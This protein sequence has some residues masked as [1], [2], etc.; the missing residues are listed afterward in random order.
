[1]RT[2][3]SSYSQPRL[4]GGICGGI[5]QPRASEMRVIA[6]ASAI[7]R[8]PAGPHSG[9]RMS[10][11]GRPL[12]QQESELRSTPEPSAGFAEGQAPPGTRT[13][14]GP[15]APR[16]SSTRWVAVPVAGHSDDMTTHILIP[17]LPASS[18]LDRLAAVLFPTPM[19]PLVR[20]AA[21]AYPMRLRSMTRHMSPLARSA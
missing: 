16:Y 14:D 13:P 18:I 6:G 19:R 7:V 12:G 17:R 8:E 4:V 21:R 10:K 5:G 11:G 1:M 9:P 2:R 15:V 3:R 20:A